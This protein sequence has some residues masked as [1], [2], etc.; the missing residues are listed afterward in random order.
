MDAEMVAL[1][2]RIKRRPKEGTLFEAIKC[3]AQACGFVAYVFD[4]HPD[5]V[6]EAVKWAEPS[7]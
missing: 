5:R 2:R 7:Q 1:Y 3:H 4:V 6:A